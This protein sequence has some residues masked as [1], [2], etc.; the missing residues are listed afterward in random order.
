LK[1]EKGGVS[2][3]HVKKKNGKPRKRNRRPVTGNQIRRRR[4]E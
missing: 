3:G 2:K 4:K 1:T